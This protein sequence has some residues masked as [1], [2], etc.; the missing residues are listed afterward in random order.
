MVWC[1]E[2]D[3]WVEK[4]V[5]PVYSVGTTVVPVLPMNGSSSGTGVFTLVT[6]MYVVHTCMYVC[7]SGEALFTSLKYYIKILTIDFFILLHVTYSVQTN[8]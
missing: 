2:R 1:D 6:Y 8:K 3:V 4:S 7:T 5:V